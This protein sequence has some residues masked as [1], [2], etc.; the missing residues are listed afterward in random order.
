M[1]WRMPTKRELNLMYS[2]KSNIGGFNDNYYWSSSEYDD[3][4]ARGQDFSNG[5]QGHNV[6][7]YTSNVRAVRAF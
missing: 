6:K 2:Q 1:D 5:N 4:N 7:D 3:N